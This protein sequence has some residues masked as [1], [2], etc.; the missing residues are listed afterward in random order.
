MSRK[1]LRVAANHFAGKWSARRSAKRKY[2]QRILLIADHWDG[3]VQQ[4]YHFMLGYL[5]PLALWISSHPNKPIMV[6]DCGPM[7]I[8]FNALHEGIDIEIVPPGGALHLV[9]GNRIDHVILQGLDDPH[10]FN[11]H[12][13]LAGAAALVELLAPSH[14]PASSHTFR[15]SHQVIVIDRQS[16]E[17]FYHSDASET[18]MSGSERRSTPNIKGVIWESLTDLD[19]RTID[20][21]D[22]PPQEQI[23]TM[24]ESSVLVGQHGAGLLHMVWMKPGSSVIEIEP[25]LP[26][27]VRG[28]FA[29]LAQCLGHKYISIEQDSVHADINATEL[30]KAIHKMA[31]DA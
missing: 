19:V 28:L 7:N 31:E 18:H 25:P 11:R 3:S 29:Q 14:E 17:T 5:F 1:N 23:A 22:V 10:R 9:I 2:R 6:R 21:A 12:K 8:W 27:E 20:F 13:L 4:F 24:R 26:K 30:M 16:N 15:T